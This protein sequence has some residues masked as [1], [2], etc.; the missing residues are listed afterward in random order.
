MSD[1]KMCDSCEEIL[2]VDEII[3]MEEELE[4]WD[5]KNFVAYNDICIHCLEEIEAHLG[6]ELLD[7][8]GVSC[9]CGMCCECRVE[10]YW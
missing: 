9:N 2:A 6:V 8:E 1:V 3:Q 5:G 7:D 10:S 4:G